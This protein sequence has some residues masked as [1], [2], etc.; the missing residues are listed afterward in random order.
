MMQLSIPPRALKELAG[1]KDGSVHLCEI[2]R[3]RLPS[4]QD[5]TDPDE[6]PTK[7]RRRLQFCVPRSAEPLF[8]PTALPDSVSDIAVYSTVFSCDVFHVFVLEG[9]LQEARCLVLMRL[10]LD[11]F[12]PPPHIHLIYIFI[13]L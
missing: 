13:L 9:R 2:K 8:K 1:K 10:S 12:P 4:T 11:T 6:I 5:K 3:H 7:Q